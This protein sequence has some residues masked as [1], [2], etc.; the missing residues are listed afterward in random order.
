[1]KAFVITPEDL[2]LAFPSAASLPTN[3]EG[4]ERIK[5]EAELANLAAGWPTSRLVAIWNKLPGVPQVSKFTDRK[6]GVTRLW[7]AMQALD[8]SAALVAPNTT[9]DEAS[10]SPTGTPKRKRAKGSKGPATRQEGTDASTKKA[11]LL[12]LLRQPNGATLA[13]LMEA[14][15]W[16]A[17]SVRGFISGTLKKKMGLTVESSKRPEGDRSYSLTEA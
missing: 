13:D 2:V 1:M 4:L 10:P 9:S 6:T 5:S 7:K 17:H 12:K 8:A 16:Q 15:G 11:A 14:T 3:L